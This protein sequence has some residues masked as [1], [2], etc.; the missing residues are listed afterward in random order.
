MR[1][2]IT[3]SSSLVGS[4]LGAALAGDHE[5][6]TLDRSGAGQPT[7][8]GDARDRELAA[9]AS[10]E[11]DAIVH[12]L[13]AASADLD[14]A[15]LIDLATR[16]TYNLLTTTT[17]ERFILVSTL[18]IF[19]AYPV[20]WR[21]SEWWAPR[22]STDAADLAPYLAE[23]TARELSRVRPVE[24]IAL[25]LGE[26]VVPEGATGS[27][28][29]R[30]LHVEDAVQAIER[31]LAYAPSDH[32]RGAGWSVF[33]IPGG[34]RG[35]RFPLGLAGQ[36]RF[37][38]APRHDLT[39]SE[40]VAASTAPAPSAAV[41]VP[42]A[43][44]A[45][46]RVVIYGAGGPL[47]AVAADNLHH[48][49]ILRLTDAR[50]LEA[51]VASGER[52]SPF[53]PLPRLLD[54]PHEREV[55]D[56]TDYAQVLRAA[57][58]MDAIINCSVVRPHPV[59]AFRVNMLGAYNVMRAAVE[60]GIQRIVHTGPFQL[61][62]DH[63]AGYTY[64]WDLAD[65]TPARPGDDLYILTKLL[66]QEICR[67][68]AEERKLEVPALLF[69]AFVA[70]ES[71]PPEPLGTFPFS[72]SWADAAAAIRQALRIPSFPRPFQILHIQADLPHGKYRNTKA[73]HLLDW[74]PKDQLE[75]HWLRALDPERNA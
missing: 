7:Y 11:C 50:P 8:V 42:R 60:L 5:I 66:G 72:I 69:C 57:Q 63:P 21:I 29:L 30:A 23:V 52:Q 54:A 26:P 41:A 12:I 61:G 4:T 70:P 20:E 56:V 67:I 75:A 27:A 38:Y 16:S 31:A 33:H 73:K 28:D 6:T 24:V 10:T 46:R 19:E 64:D 71:P 37:G 45:P 48:D 58:G 3:E 47:G 15:E 17:A 36:A 68:F 65:D 14:P 1:I 2:L 44:G 22:P 34:G 39:G 18:R 51:I 59:Q 55:V 74:Q 35:A 62:L 49:H 13:P 25:R 32:E 40:A 53:A 43:S 9:H